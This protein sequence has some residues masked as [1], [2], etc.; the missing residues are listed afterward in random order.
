MAAPRQPLKLN[1]RMR[2]MLENEHAGIVDALLDLEPYARNN[3][4]DKWSQGQT[5]HFLKRKRQLEEK[6]GLAVNRADRE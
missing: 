5:R 1:E 2:K 3:P 4:D 6:L